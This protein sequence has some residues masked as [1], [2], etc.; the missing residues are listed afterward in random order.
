MHRH[1]C[2]QQQEGSPT[3]QL[4]SMQQPERAAG[5]ACTAA[6]APAAA[7]GAV[8]HTPYVAAGPRAGLGYLLLLS[9]YHNPHHQQ[10]KHDLSWIP[11]AAN[12]QA[13]ALDCC[14]PM[15]PTRPPYHRGSWSAARPQLSGA[16]VC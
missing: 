9:A 6:A 2:K 3:E 10:Q 8:Q 13:C 14:A 16:G 4:A 1:S 5:P 12:Y 7:G 11:A 15:S